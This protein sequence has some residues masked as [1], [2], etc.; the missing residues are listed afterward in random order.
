IAGLAHASSIVWD[1][2]VFLTTAV[3]SDPKTQFKPGLYGEGTSAS[4]VTPH[5]WL[6]YCLDKR[7]GKVLWERTAYEGVPKV[8]RHIKSSHANPTPATDG[9]HL[10]VSFAS[11]G[12][13]CYDLDGKLL[14]KRDL[15]IIDP[16]AFNDPDLQWGAGSSP[17]LYQ[18][19]VIVQCD[20]QKDS[21]L[22]AYDADS[23]QPVWSVPRDE[24]P[25]WGTPTIYEGPARVELI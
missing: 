25:S 4:D 14:W 11:E 23:G 19:L 18:N 7:T 12:L 2:R 8:K 13:Y 21:F 3:S 24:P 16:G 17:I 20:R 9:K 22:A 1:N 5:R 15:G 6:V 10:V